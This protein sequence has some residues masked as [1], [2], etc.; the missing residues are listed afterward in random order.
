MNEDIRVL[1]K[2]EEDTLYNTLLSKV[3]AVYNIFSNF[4]GE[5][6]V[7]LQAIIS[8]ETVIGWGN[9]RLKINPNIS[10]A[11]LSDSIERSAACN[12]PSIPFILIY[13]PQVTITNEYG[14]SVD[15][16]ELYAK[17]C[18]DYKGSL[19]GK[20]GLNRAEYTTD[21]MK[22]NYMHSHVDVIPRNNFTEFRTPCTGTGPIN[23]TI[24][25]LNRGYDEDF[26]NLFCLELSK[27]VT[28]ESIVGTP[29]HRLTTIGAENNTTTHELRSFYNKYVYSSDEPTIKLINSF[30]RHI[31]EE[32][33]LKF[34]FE[35]D[36]YTLA[37][38]FV[39]T[40]VTLSNEFIKWYNVNFFK[41]A[42]NNTDNIHAEF[43]HNIG[44]LFSMCFLFKGIVT[45][46]KIVV[47]DNDVQNLVETYTNLEGTRICMFKGSAVTLH[48]ITS[49]TRVTDDN[50]SILLNNNIISF[51]IFR[52]LRILNYRYGREKKINT[53][54]RICYI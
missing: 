11:T 32:K 24:C 6:R 39:E 3:N 26:W 9:G 42:N 35:T 47:I 7:D 2:E 15:I 54:E 52:I 33:I 13:F 5:D 46:N 25:T 37:T 14:D 20:F 31:I 45:A 1:T 22:S 18:I 41:E 8:K 27:Y 51:I 21:Q 12:P 44:M 4:Y 19:C 23:N 16:T 29:Y 38:S 10:F 49:N 40:T 36:T 30:T 17:V 28:V 48:I 43:H 50:K 34:R 53:G